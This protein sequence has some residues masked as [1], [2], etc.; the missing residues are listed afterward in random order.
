[1]VDG[2]PDIVAANWEQPHIAYL[3]D[4]R[5]HFKKGATFG[6]GREQTW[7]IVLGDMDLDGDLDAVVG[8]V[9]IGFW[10]SDLNGDRQSEQFGRESRNEPSR[11]Y[12][13]DGAG[14]FTPASPLST[15]T[16]HTRPVALGDLDHDGD[17]DVVMGN[18]C[19][20]NHIFFNPLRGP[21]SQ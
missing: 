2:D 3:N 8:N 5:G 15:G 21:R 6:S 20:P 18:T 13:N 12:I 4:S 16:D 7:T 11:L 17:L 19:Q 9:N 10:N 14:R 1:M